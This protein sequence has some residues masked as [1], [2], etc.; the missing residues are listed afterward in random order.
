MSNGTRQ[1]NKIG[2]EKWDQTERQGVDIRKTRPPFRASL[3]NN[4]NTNK[5]MK[6]KNKKNK[7]DKKNK[8]KKNKNK[9]NKNGNKRN[10]K[11]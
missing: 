10:K 2:I 6:N 4:K 8:N 11:Q 7:K 9:K 5:S 3:N 1:K